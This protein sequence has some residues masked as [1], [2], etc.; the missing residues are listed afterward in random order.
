MRSRRSSAFGCAAQI[1]F[2]HRHWKTTT[3]V[4]GTA[5]G[6]DAACSAIAL[7]AEGTSERNEHNEHDEHNGDNEHNE[8]DV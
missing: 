4:A 3:L 5:V 1:G 2:P 7:K 8:H 6:Y